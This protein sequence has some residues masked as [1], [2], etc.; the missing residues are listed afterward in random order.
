MVSYVLWEH[1][2]EV[3][4]FLPRPFWG[5]GLPGVVA[6]LA[7]RIFRSVRV[8]YSPPSFRSSKV[9]H[10]ADNRETMD[11]Y[12]S[13]GPISAGD[14]TGIRVCLRSIIL[15]VRISPGAPIRSLVKWMITAGYGPAGGSS[16]LSGPAN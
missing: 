15:R 2:A 7:M 10:P 4:F 6:A 13:K 8:R 11:R 12:H 3:R 9:E 16:I 5:M 1:V 14:G